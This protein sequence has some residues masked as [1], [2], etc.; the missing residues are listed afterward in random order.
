[1]GRSFKMRYMSNN[2]CWKIAQ[3]IQSSF[4]IGNLCSRSSLRDV[5]Y[6]V[7]DCMQDEGFGELTDR[8]SLVLLISKMALA[9]WE[10]TI[11]STKNE[12]ES[13]EEES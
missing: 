6:A 5:S 12:I 8:K 2:D 7:Q 13:F 4:E 1:M 10:S 3:L 11:T 9:E